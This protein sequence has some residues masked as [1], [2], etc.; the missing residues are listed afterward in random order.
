MDL[1]QDVDLLEPARRVQARWYW[2]LLALL[3]GAALGWGFSLVRPPVYRASAILAVSNDYGVTGPLEL[4]VEDRA[5]DRVHQLILADDTLTQAMEELKGVDPA[6]PAWADLGALRAR[7]TLEQR[8][9]RWELLATDRDP[10]TAARIANAWAVAAV[11]QLEVAQQH[12]WKLLDLRG[13]P[14]MV[15]CFRLLPQ[16]APEARFWECVSAA[17]ELDSGQQAL[18][19]AE[20]KAS[21]GILPSLSF[22]WVDHAQPPST[23]VVWDRGALVL[24]GAV[25]GLVA[26]VWIS[27]MAPRRSGRAPVE[28]AEGHGGVGT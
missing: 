6:N 17:P 20:M 9:A 3:A 2:L 5:L 10:A 8:L 11:T 26:G 12:A 25:L 23:P 27:L 22:E 1:T 15:E 13:A 7:L 16:P 4:V 21:R 14:V 18:L 28:P 19:R 24:A